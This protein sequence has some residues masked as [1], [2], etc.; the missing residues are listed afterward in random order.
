MVCHMRCRDGEQG[1]RELPDYEGIL[2]FGPSLSG[3]RGLGSAFVEFIGE[4]NSCS[5]IEWLC[6]RTPKEGYETAINR[7][8]A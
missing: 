1:R 5:L 6:H 3:H 8:A 2:P 7:V 4:Y